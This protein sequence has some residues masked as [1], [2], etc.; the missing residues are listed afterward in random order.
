MKTL[1]ALFVLSFF[2]GNSYAERQNVSREMVHASLLARQGSLPQS[3]G[4]CWRFVKKALVKAGAVKSYPKTNLACEAG[5]ELVE[6]YGFKKLRVSSPWKAPVGS[7]LVYAANSRY[8][9]GHVEIRGSNDFISDY[10]GRRPAAFRFI[11]AY[12]RVE[13]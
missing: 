13:S 6:V 7:V 8:R 2:V 3:T 11:G 1:L 12:A 9:A 10:R 4:Y 5:K